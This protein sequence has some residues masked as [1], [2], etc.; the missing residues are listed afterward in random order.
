MRTSG[1]VLL[2]LIVLFVGWVASN[3]WH[4]YQADQEM[5]VDEIAY[6]PTGL[7]VGAPFNLSLKMPGYPTA[8]VALLPLERNVKFI[9]SELGLD[10]LNALKTV[11]RFDDGYEPWS[12]GRLNTSAESQLPDQDRT[13]LQ[14]LDTACRARDGKENK[15]CWNFERI[16]GSSKLFFTHGGQRVAL[17]DAETNVLLV[18]YAGRQFEPR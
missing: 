11:T 5:M 8:A 2:L 10:Y 9:I 16:R 15:A 17:V 13:M 7:R 18:V 6:V 3:H 1:R 14:R 4:K 12:Y